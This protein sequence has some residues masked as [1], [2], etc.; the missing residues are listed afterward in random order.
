MLM[1]LHDSL[2]V[3]ELK[4]ITATLVRLY[5]VRL[6][7]GANPRDVDPILGAVIRPKSGKCDL[8]F[9]SRRE[10]WW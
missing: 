2:A 8:V 5:E 3:V 10:R 7:D 1:H 9:E 6:P 4:V